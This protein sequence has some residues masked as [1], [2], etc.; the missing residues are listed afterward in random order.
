MKDSVSSAAR[1]ALLAAALGYSAATPF[2]FHP[3]ALSAEKSAN[4][5]AELEQAISDKHFP[6]ALFLVRRLLRSFPE[7]SVFLRREAEIYHGLNDF[8]SE[9]QAYELAMALSPT[10]TENCPYLGRSY[11]SQG[12]GE[13]ALDADRRCWEA[14]PTNVDM[15]IDYAGALEQANRV[16][17]S[18]KF[19]ESVL[20]QAPTY[21]DAAVG[22]AR[23]D[24]A[25]R[26]PQDA[27]KRLERVNKLKPNADALAVQARIEDS[28]GRHERARNLVRQAIAL[29]PDSEDLKN[30][31]R[32][33]EKK[34]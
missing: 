33:L 11:R 15:M 8:K 31:L 29:S 21:A 1:W 5:R 3:P 32:N 4:L 16:P 19:F 24:M 18:R 7:D 34:P 6:E 28:L 20:A 10:P 17:E 27:L 22:L 26:K 9:S 23:L 14:E 13:K 30:L 25:E 2:S 12:L